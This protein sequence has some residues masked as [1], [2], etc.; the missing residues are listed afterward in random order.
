MQVLAR[1]IL[2]VA[3]VWHP[4]LGLARGL[5]AAAAIKACSVG[6][7]CCCGGGGSCPMSAPALGCACGGGEKPIPAAPAPSTRP[8]DRADG[9]LALVPAA[10][11]VTAP[12]PVAP[13]RVIA[14][15]EAPR[16]DGPSIQSILCVW[17]T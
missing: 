17:L 7:S 3:L 8:G 2:A 14:A 5:C 16:R 6:P 12:M 10:L 9:G 11:A 1:I 4:V 15:L 13:A